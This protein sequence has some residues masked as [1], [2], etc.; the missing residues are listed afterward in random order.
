MDTTNKY[1]LPVSVLLAGLFIG[2]AVIWNGMHPSVSG[3]PQKNVA[4]DGVPFI[5][6]ED[7][8]VTIAVWTD[9]QCPYCKA[10]EVGGIPQIPMDPA[11][12]EIVR[13]YVNTGKAKIVFFDFP[14]L[15]QDS[16]DGARYGHAIWKLY[17]DRY[18]AWR[19]AMYEAQDDEGDVGFGDPASID[20]LNATIPGI[21]A[22]KVAADVAANRDAYDALI[23]AQRA[24]GQKFGISATPSF[25]I[26]AELMQGAAEYAKFKL[27][28]DTALAS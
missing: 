14:F 24:E 27:A 22:A 7:A 1:F 19:T 11:I 2:G 26:G 12:P 13:D 15:G 16:I 6:K 25:I 5:G 20:A 10:V 3:A 9:Y 21:D 18:F 4:T 8:P 17:P 28:I 23:A